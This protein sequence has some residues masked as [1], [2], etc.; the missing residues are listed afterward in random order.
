VDLEDRRYQFD[1]PDHRYVDSGGAH[2]APNPQ[3]AVVPVWNACSDPNFVYD[4]GAGQCP[5]EAVAPGGGTTYTVGAFAQIFVEG[6]STGKAS[7][8]ETRLIHIA[9][10]V[11]GNGSLDIDEVGPLA[12][13]VRLVRVP[14]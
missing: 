5:A 12:L 14:E 2:R 11:G 4:A 3:L 9:D 8:V 7:G 6:M 1:S 13:P 10:C